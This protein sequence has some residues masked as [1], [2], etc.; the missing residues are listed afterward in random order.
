M[1]DQ[2][3]DCSDGSDEHNCSK[4]SSL[5][6]SNTDTCSKWMGMKTIAACKMTF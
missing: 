4:Y 1:C 3:A 2:Y 6:F 5:F